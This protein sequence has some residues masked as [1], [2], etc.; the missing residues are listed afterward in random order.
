MSAGTGIA[1]SEYNL[2]DETTRI[3]QIWIMPTEFGTA[4]S[5]T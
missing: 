1:H 5:R 2:E 3:F 4:P